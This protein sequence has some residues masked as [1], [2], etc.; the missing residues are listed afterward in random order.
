MPDELNENACLSTGTR[1]RERRDL[2]FLS[3][4]TVKEG[5]TSR[6]SIPK[7]GRE[8]GAELA[9]PSNRKNGSAGTEGV[10]KE[11]SGGGAPRAAGAEKAEETAGACF[12]TLNK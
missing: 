9:L 5:P 10:E 2:S 3:R 12:L 7:S 8:L 11:M 1:E 4:I 6:R